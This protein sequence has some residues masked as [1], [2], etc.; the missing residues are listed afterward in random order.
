MA[1]TWDSR[2]ISL[3]C[4][5]QKERPYTAGGHLTSRGGEPRW[6]EVTSSPD[7]CLATHLEHE[8]PTPGRAELS[9]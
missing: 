4:E 9:I 2:T 6:A 3:A 5:Q 7:G 1:H 8:S